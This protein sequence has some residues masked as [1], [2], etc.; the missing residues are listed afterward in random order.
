MFSDPIV[1]LIR[2][3]VPLV[4]GALVANLPFLADVINTD[5][6]VMVVVGAYYSLAAILEAKINPMF[7]YLLGVPKTKAVTDA[8]GDKV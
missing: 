4:I 3:Y 2:T 8:A 1:R 6:L 5:A 7:G